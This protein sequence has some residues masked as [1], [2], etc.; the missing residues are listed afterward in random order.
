MVLPHL[1]AD[2]Y[3]QPPERNMIG[4]A[5]KT[6]SPQIDGVNPSKLFDTV[7]GHKTTGLGIALT[8]PGEF[9]PEEVEAIPP[10]NGFQ[11]P[12]TFGDHLFPDAVAGDY[13][14]LV[15]GHS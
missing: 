12:N 3:Q 14:N 11:Y 9:L 1:P 4:H 2:G 6:D 8:V 5:G 13:C 10:A 15:C 7:F